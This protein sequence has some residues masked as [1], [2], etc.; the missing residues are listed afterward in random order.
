MRSESPSDRG[1]GAGVVV[2]YGLRNAALLRG[3]FKE[4]R[5]LC[6]A[7][8]RKGGSGTRPTLIIDPAPI[9]II[10]VL[11]ELVVALVCPVSVQ[12]SALAY[13]SGSVFYSDDAFQ[14]LN[15]NIMS[16]GMP[17]RLFRVVP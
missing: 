7:P 10:Q 15:A 11:E 12:C 3:S 5:S 2:S 16:L 13:R 17:L 4:N 8:C 9:L 6:K 1:N 14:G